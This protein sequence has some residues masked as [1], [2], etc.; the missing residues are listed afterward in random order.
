MEEK[1][2]LIDG[3]SILNR[4]FYGIHAGMTNF[5][6][7]HTN[8]VYGFLNILLKILDEENPEYLAVAFDVKAPTFRH[9]LYEAYKGTR[10]GMPDELHEQVPITKEVLSA[11]GIPTV[12]LAG[13]EADDILGTLSARCETAGLSVVLV[14]GDR[15]LLQLASR[16]TKVRIPRTKAG[17]TT[18]EDYLEQDVMERL[19]VTPKE[20]IDVKALMGDSSDNIPG[21]TGIGEKTAYA[22]I[23][24]YHSL[25]AIYESLEIIKPERAKKALTNGREQAELSR[26]LATIDRE[27]PVEFSL[28]AARVG[29]LFTPEA[30]ELMKRLE[31]K[32]LLNRFEAGNQTK[33]AVEKQFLLVDDLSGAERAFEEASLA[34]WVGLQLI[35]EQG[36]ILGLSLAWGEEDIY[37]IEAKGLLTGEYLAEKTAGL[38]EQKKEVWAL[39]LKEMLPFLEASK[40][41]EFSEKE[42]LSDACVAAY[43][44]NPLK[45][46]Y[47]YDG[48]AG[49]YLGMTVPSRSDLLGKAAYG[50]A[51]SENP[52]A[53]L[54][55]FGYMAYTAFAA[56]PILKKKLEETGMS[57]L[58]LTIEMPL[59]YSLYHME[60]EGIQVEREELSAYG[61]TLKVQI[62]RLEGEIY[63][64]SGER[65]NINSPKQL[66]VILFEKLG[67]P[68]GKKTKTGYSTSAD[69]LEKLAPEHPFVAKILEY[70]Q[71]AKLKSTYAD[72]LT[73]FIARDGRIHGK[74]HQTITATGRISS[75]EP[76]LQNI[77]VR[78]A[79]GREIRKVFVPKE[80][81]VFVD[82]D[83]S[84]IE[85]RVLAHMSGDK[86]LIEAYHQAEDI[87]RIT[88]S[89][90][91]HTP[92]EEVTDLQRR[93]AK[94][95]N[96]G[97]VY[98]ISAFGLSEGL[99]ISRKEAVDYIDQYFET[100]PGVKAFLDGLVIQAKEQGYVSTLYGRRRPVPELASSNFMQRNFGERVAM[101][102]PIQGTAAD[103]MKIAMVGVDRRLK[104]EGLASRLIL[105]I[106]DELLVETA[107]SEVEQVK[108][109]LR[110]E[111]DGAAKLSVPLEIDMNVG[112]SWFETK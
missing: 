110:E 61:E 38:C 93:N 27:C 40:K 112:K 28:E 36:E 102:S 53:A 98:G 97:I 79:L 31:L 23:K 82:A 37:F 58:F 13:Y 63:D 3:Y 90:V 48:L 49:E 56:G 75:A 74:F 95:V 83:Y 105:Q 44:L 46:D 106:H 25:E 35:A 47:T 85:L 33:N 84:Q 43:L 4:A 80:G 54:T 6:G 78:M 9:K 111:M 16:K 51:L 100:Y 99:S 42:G 91:F 94:A 11:M 41:S 14:S 104:K 8:A 7:L 26:T 72:G 64:L 76:N 89:Q 77:P 108:A 92:F 87:H 55:C 81:F 65:F 32:S 45:S 86:R 73:A 21:V 103:I 96:F 2:V 18:V 109:I 15:D 69:V 22:L 71:L 62:E 1:I 59:I 12:E 68:Y 60:R 24:E 17:Q 70:R 19:G 66:G 30:Y 34:E 29:E 67:L 5:E 101:N 107:L 20:F 10:K 52:K 57:D 88:A 39:D 50:T